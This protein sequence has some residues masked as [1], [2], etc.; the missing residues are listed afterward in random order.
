[1]ATSFPRV[2]ASLG[3]EEGG[4]T[5]SSSR[6]TFIPLNSSKKEDDDLMAWIAACSLV[7]TIFI[8]SLSRSNGVNSSESISGM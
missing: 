2:G 4:L 6:I 8:I 1:M 3:I 5:T 7:I